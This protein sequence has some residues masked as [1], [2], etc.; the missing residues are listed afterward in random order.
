MGTAANV[1]RSCVRRR[2][3]VAT[4]QR[5]IVRVTTRIGRVTKRNWSREPFSA[6]R[7]IRMIGRWSAQTRDRQ[8][9]RPTL[10]S[11]SDLLRCP[12]LVRYLRTWAGRLQKAWAGRKRA[13]RQRTYATLPMRQMQNQ[14]PR[15]ALDSRCFGTR[16]PGVS[17]E[18]GSALL[19]DRARPRQPPTDYRDAHDGPENRKRRESARG[20]DIRC[21][22]VTTVYFGGS[23]V[24][25]LRLPR[26]V[27]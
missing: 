13:F 16:G 27:R 6:N 12:Q 23:T 14:S 9:F 20:C 7:N 4:E 1:N 22:R 26:T 8:K 10:L 2:T 5:R 17:N 25:P 24:S 11:V 19:D 15:D 3:L 21:A 18:P